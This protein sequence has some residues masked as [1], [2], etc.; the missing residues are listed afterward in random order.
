MLKP[1]SRSRG[2]RGIWSCLVKSQNQQC[3]GTTYEVYFL[4]HTFV[5]H[6]NL[7]E[8]SSKDVCMCEQA[9]VEK[10]CRSPNMWGRN[11]DYYYYLLSCFRPFHT[12]VLIFVPSALYM[13]IQQFV[14]HFQWFNKELTAFTPTRSCHSRPSRERHYIYSIQTNSRV[15]NEQEKKQEKCKHSVTRLTMDWVKRIKSC[16]MSPLLGLSWICVMILK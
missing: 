12:C 4:I 6:S 13:W 7:P 10:T 16:L 15:V 5:S 14:Q 8:V 3:V 1:S 2:Q 9:G 11:W